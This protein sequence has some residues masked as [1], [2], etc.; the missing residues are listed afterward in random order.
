MSTTRY[1]EYSHIHVLSVCQNL[2]MILR[3]S[4]KLI[5]SKDTELGSQY[6]MKDV[7]DII[8]E[9]IIVVKFIL[10]DNVFIHIFKMEKEA[11][12]KT[13][14]QFDFVKVTTEFKRGHRE[15]RS[16]T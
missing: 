5:Q 8:G 14:G 4:P 11:H 15:G 2:N 3:A 16:N 6:I 12:D 7:L 13:F 1:V 10:A 9:P